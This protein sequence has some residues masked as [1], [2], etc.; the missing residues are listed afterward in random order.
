M[1]IRKEPQYGPP[2]EAAYDTTTWAEAGLQF[3]EWRECFMTL[4]TM[5]K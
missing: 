4:D 1:I 5:K 2:K 3:D